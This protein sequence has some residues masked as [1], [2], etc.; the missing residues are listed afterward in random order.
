MN[1]GI[2]SENLTSLKIEKEKT[3]KKIHLKFYKLS[4]GTLSI[5]CI[6][7]NIS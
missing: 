3:L 1:I 5:H 2:S 4:K 7:K 6:D